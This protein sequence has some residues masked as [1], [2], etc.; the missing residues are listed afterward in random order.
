MKTRALQICVGAYSNGGWNIAIVE[1]LYERGMKVDS[2]ILLGPMYCSLAQLQAYVDVATE[3]LV[4]L[5]RER[6]AQEGREDQGRIPAPTR[7]AV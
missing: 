3:Q 6:L 7:A 4:S 5:E 1:D 2:R